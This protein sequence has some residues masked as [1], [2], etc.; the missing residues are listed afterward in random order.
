MEKILQIDQLCKRYGNLKALD[1]LSLEVRKG[2]ILGLLGPNGSGKTTTLGIVLGTLFADSGTYSWFEQGVQSNQLTRVGA[3]LETPN[4]Y[5]Y[6]NA[7]QNLKIIAHIKGIPNPDYTKILK[8]VNLLERAHSP[9]VSYSFGMKQRLAIGAA[10]VGDPE[11][12]IFDEPT[13]GLDPEGI[14]EIRDIIL[15][16]ARTGKTIIM[17]SHILSEVEKICS[18]IA[19]LKKGKLLAYG[20]V[21]SI[22]H[23]KKTF[24]LGSD[25]KNTSD[26]LNLLGKQ[27]WTEDLSMN[28]QQLIELVTKIEIP[29]GQINALCFENQIILHH[30]E[31]KKKKLEEEFIEIIQTHPL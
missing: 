2:Q 13:N 7:I 18:H 17:A 3:L 22:I 1:H 28:A 11:V 20:P 30:L 31:E 5:P 29:A 16:I 23:S 19:I 25:P 12:L 24:V 27:E 21:G 14:I 6:L 10:M 9:F 8:A 4:F 26:L 15:N